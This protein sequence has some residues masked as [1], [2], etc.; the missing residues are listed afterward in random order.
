[1]SR[2]YRRILL[3]CLLATAAVGVGVQDSVARTSHRHGVPIRRSL[4][5][6]SGSPVV[7]A[8]LRA[9]RGRWR[10]AKHFSYQWKRCNA[11][12]GRCKL[13]RRPRSKRGTRRQPANSYKL[14]SADI[15]H[16]IRVTVIARN[17]RG[18][19]SATSRPTKL[20]RRRAAKTP[21][22]ARPTPTPLPAPTS[23][24]G[25]HV[26]GNRL[27]NAHG[28]TIELHG[29]DQSGSEYECSQGY[30]IFDNGTASASASETAQEAADLV[31][32]SLWRVNS[33]FIGLNEDCWLGINGIKAA[34][35][36]QN[37]INAIKSAVSSAERVGIY[38]VIGL[39]W[40]DP[41]SEV[42]NGSDGN[43]GGQP[44]MPD[45]DHA[46]LF[47]EEVAQTFRND[48]NVIF[49]LQEE[50]HPDSNNTNLAA[51]KCWSQGD[52]QYGTTSDAATFG[53]AP[54]PSS[55]AQ[56][57]NETSTNG[58][59]H[60]ATVGMQSLVNIIRGTGAANVIQLPGLAY[61]NM[62]ACS[63]TGNPA[64]CGM[65][66][67]PDGVR[68]SDRLTN[69]QLMA[70]FDM[71]PDAGQICDT[72]GCYTATL[73]PVA[74]AMPVDLGEIGAQ[75]NVDTQAN[76]LLNWMDARR[77]SYY[78]WAWDSWSEL[79]SSDAKGIPDSPWGADY[80]RRL[81]ALP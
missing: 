14:T 15:G 6:V 55:R 18:S 13:I 5:R 67:S 34:Y 65:L 38:P 23:G 2:R 64:A 12:G 41:G 75:N 28:Q 58:S 47:W 72:T 46:P 4:P 16:K 33:V 32:M 1:M 17:R 56:H 45:N 31:V 78:A 19:T 68:V 43:G 40:G 7:G 44:A 60:Y 11:H 52:V 35:S 49:R 51:W 53:T 70:D 21:A 61:A 9:G 10:K 79:I 59:T 27:V 42:P 20:I 50:P 22:P 36:G 26:V 80:K 39:Y 24:P 69:P 73:A 66:D 29:V 77:Q 57:C 30:G 76:V 74:A 62:A 48:P 63:P 71:Y 3:T 54:R 8:T 81:A 25:V 37:Y